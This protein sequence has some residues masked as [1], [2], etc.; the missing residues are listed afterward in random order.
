MAVI[1]ERILMLTEEWEQNLLLLDAYSRDLLNDIDFMQ[2]C[3]EEVVSRLRS[4]A[5]TAVSQSRA[6]LILVGVVMGRANQAL[7]AAQTAVQDSESQLATATQNFDNSQRSL[8]LWKT[9][10]AKAQVWLKEAIARVKSAEALVATARSNLSSAESILSQANAELN[11]ARSA[12]ETVGYDKDNNP[13]RRP[14]DTGPYVAA[15]NRAQSVVDS[16][17]RQ[18]EQA[19]QELRAANANQAAAQ[20]RLD[21]CFETQKLAEQSLHLCQRAKANA[22]LG[23][24]EAERAKSNAKLSVA[25]ITNGLR[26]ARQEEQ[27]A[28]QMNLN[29]MDSQQLVSEARIHAR[30]IEVA[31]SDATNVACGARLE[32]AHRQDLLRRFLAPTRES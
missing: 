32:L 2:R 11:W 13:I 31:S 30:Y 3:A 15:V 5:G 22:S 18:L 23:L 9:N 8:T 20:R 27:L 12:Y 29:A 24:R 14:V 4:E 19:I 26:Y 21:Y 28:E 16:C 7:S 10:V 25:H 17:R 1:P 6:D